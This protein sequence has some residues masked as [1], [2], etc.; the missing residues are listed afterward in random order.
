MILVKSGKIIYKKNLKVKFVY[1]FRY[2]FPKL[3]NPTKYELP[4][5]ENDKNVNCRRMFLQLFNDIS[6]DENEPV[7]GSH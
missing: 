6:D 2:V 1:I 3:S 7:Y 4:K 5:S